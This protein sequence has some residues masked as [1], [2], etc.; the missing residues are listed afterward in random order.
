MIISDKPLQKV[1]AFVSAD[2]YIHITAFRLKGDWITKEI[3][4]SPETFQELLK[5]VGAGFIPI[6]PKTEEGQK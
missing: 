5:V 2:G 3:N 1:D 6:K 4:L